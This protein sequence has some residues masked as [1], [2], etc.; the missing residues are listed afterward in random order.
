MAEIILY[1]IIIK[2][3]INY[4]YQNSRIFSAKNHCIYDDTVVMELMKSK[5]VFAR[6][7]FNAL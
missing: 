5:Q 4:I 7:L 2:K 6:D 3:Y 1:K